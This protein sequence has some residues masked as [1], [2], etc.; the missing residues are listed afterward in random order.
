MKKL[1]LL[2]GH[3]SIKPSMKIHLHIKQQNYVQRV[4]KRRGM[5]T[6]KNVSHYVWLESLTGILF[7]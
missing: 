1:K 3:K 4:S 6:D 2:L 7:I 5:T